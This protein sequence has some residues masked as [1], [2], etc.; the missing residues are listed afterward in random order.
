V[1]VAVHTGE[2]EVR[3]GDYFGRAVNRAARLRAVAHGGQL[4]LSRATADLVADTLPGG[5]ALVDRGDRVLRDL[6]RPEYVF[7][8]C[9]ATGVAEAA[10]S[11]GGELE[12]DASLPPLPPLLSTGGPAW[13]AGRAPQLA[14]L[15]DVWK[16]AASGVRR[17][18]LVSGEPGV[19][20]TRLAAEAAQR[21]HAAGGMVL[22][23]RCEEDLGVPYEPFVEALGWF[24]QHTP[25]AELPSRL[26]RFP[27][28]L[29]RLLPDLPRIVP[30]L[31]P[32][33]R[34][35]PETERYR[36]FEAVASWLD[37][38]G[39]P[40][41]LFLVVDD[42]HWAPPPTL[43]LLAHVVRAADPAPLLVLGTFRDTEVGRHHPLA[44]VLA[45]LR[46]IE[47]IERLALA[48]LSIDE[49][50]ELLEERGGVGSGPAL[51][52]MLHEATDGNP[53]FVREVLRHA[54]ESGL[55]VG[56][57]LVPEGVREVIVSRVAR[58]SPLSQELLAIASVLGRATDL[59]TLALVADADED[60]VVDA[61]D[62][63]LAARLVEETGVGA[64]RFFHALVRTALYESLSA[65]R[66][67]RLHLRAADAY[68]R[69]SAEEAAHL[70]HHL[71]AAMPLSGPERTA[72]ACL[73]AG[74][75]ALEV[76]ADTEAAGWYR[77][78][79]AAS[80][81]EAEP[82]LSIDLLTGLGEAQRR[83]G[84][85]TFRQTLLDAA[86]RAARQG[87]AARLARAVLANNRGFTSVI[88]H[89]DDERIELIETA[90]DLA[91]SAPSAERAQLLALLAAE[92]AF[93]AD[94]HRRLAAADEA[95]AI[96]GL[97]EDVTVR[98]KVGLRRLAGCLVPDRVLA[99]VSE[100][101]DV[102]GLA[103]ASG[104]PQLRALARV[105]W[106]AALFQ[107]GSLR[108]AREATSEAM[109]IGE[110]TGHPGLRSTL[111]TMHAAAIDALGE[112]VKAAQLTQ[113]AFEL[114]QA[115][116]HPDAPMWYGGR[117]I[118]HWTY[119]G[120]ADLGATVG[121]QASSDYPRMMVLRSGWVLDRALT[122][123]TEDVADAFAG[124]SDTLSAASVDMFW[125]A[126]HFQFAVAMGFGVEDR[127]AAVLLYDRLLPYRTLHAAY[128]IGY[129]GPV[130]IALGVLARVLGDTDLALAH[131]EAAAAVI[132]GCGAARA[133]A[134]NGYQWALTLHARGTL[135]E[136]QR[137]HQL[138]EETLTY[139]RAQGYAT[140]EEKAE[141]ALA[142]LGSR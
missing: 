101:A 36:F 20:K 85:A 111:Q 99:L 47:G 118:L 93:G 116:G 15:A 105:W 127:A 137:G 131:H 39:D 28:E 55:T 128:N 122:G 63:A 130:E 87:D 117:M 12:P 58:L 133:R 13:F 1:R 73:M 52:V 10:A 75:R 126:T 139:A 54:A 59:G 3:E 33:L 92:L 107:A 98:A 50:A 110:E 86:R 104:D 72:A 80:N 27:G 64:Y 65:S 135:G 140:F 57:L 42:L 37:S 68:E 32:P 74:N 61:L 67:G 108:Q 88:G 134:L 40:G 120:Q 129:W 17:S 82:S 22:Y 51:A 94:H 46:R 113:A 18:V 66:R 25:A 2:A 78:G 45:D 62:E 29:V 83:T 14:L 5:A 121:A 142:E 112:H 38:A 6:H 21:V 97:I 44:P 124:L 35:D 34:S 125:V 30:G 43:A 11:G 84:D 76:L 96:A 77:E 53:F 109:A 115:A 69:R 31:D 102:I 119:E 81:G 9:P 49:L 114:G 95:A 26:G 89:V 23:G 132:E 71:I 136:R 41:G 106:V 138:L 91:G 48:G 60:L 56:P 7:E 8:L 16:E 19:G 4:L 90:L 24:C 100:G 123:H 70:A 79:L 103:D 141:Q